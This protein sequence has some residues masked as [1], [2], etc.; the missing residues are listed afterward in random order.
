MNYKKFHKFFYAALLAASLSSCGFFNTEDVVDPNSPSLSGTTKNPTADQVEQLAYGA[1]SATRGWVGGAAVGTAPAGAATG[2]YRYVQIAGVFGREIYVLASNDDRWYTDLYGVK[3]GALDNNNFLSLDYY[4]GYAQARRA[5]QALLEGAENSTYLTET[6]KAGA[7]GVANTLKAYSMLMLLNMQYKQGIRIEVDKDVLKPGPFVSYEQGMAEIKRLLD[8]GATQLASGA[9]PTATFVPASVLP[10]IVTGTTVTPA[11][12]RKVNRALAARVAVY[13]SDWTGALTALQGSFLNLTGSLNAG[14][15]ATFA[16]SPDVFNPF[17]QAVNSTQAQLALVHPSYLKDIEAGDK[18][19]EKVR[20]RT[21]AVSKGG[22]ASDIEPAIY[23]NNTASFPLINNEELV[24]IYAEANIQSGNLA[25][26]TKA[27][28]II[29]TTYGLKE[30]AGADNKDALIN[31]MLHQR[32]YSL[33][34][35][36]HRWIDMRRYGRLNQ[37]PLDLPTHKVF[38]QHVRPFAEDAWDQA[39]GG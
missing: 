36:G 32:R 15:M 20:K 13:S 7:K 1:L 31:E 21:S 16:G 2:M 4:N 33:F 12:F 26:G 39:N 38:E 19:A 10:G 11:D 24:L 25:E 9:F 29:R 22:L 28:N 34:Y 14:W 3:G 8:E 5:A 23:A 17:F 37:L 6:Q 30:Y 35:L 18:R 27:L